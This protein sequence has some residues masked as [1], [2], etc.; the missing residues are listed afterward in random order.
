[1]IAHQ[2]WYVLAVSSNTPV[3]GERPAVEEPVRE[4]GGRPRTKVRLAPGEPPPTTVA[5]VVATWSADRCRLTV[6]EGEKGPRTYDWACARVVESRDS[7][8]GPDAWL[9]A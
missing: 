3:W 4:T 2:R 6:A 8:P 1:M 9:L 7:L 5:A